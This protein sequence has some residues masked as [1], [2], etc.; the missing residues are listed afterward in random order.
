MTDSWIIAGNILVLL[1]Q[2]SQGCHLGTLW[3]KPPTPCGSWPAP[4]QDVS[5]QCAGPTQWTWLLMT[6]TL[7]RTRSGA[8]WFPAGDKPSQGGSRMF[9]SLSVHGHLYPCLV[10]RYLE[11]RTRSSSTIQSVNQHQYTNHPRW[12]KELEQQC[13]QH[14]ASFIEK[15]LLWKKSQLN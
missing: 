8:Q 6:D 11:G 4:F 13:H 5:L 14:A 3:A 12:D 10:S 15:V 9:C 1:S 2:C 7:L